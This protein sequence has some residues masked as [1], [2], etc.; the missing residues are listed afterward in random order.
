MRSLKPGDMPT[1]KLMSRFVACSW[2]FS[3]V[4]VVGWWAE[5]NFNFHGSAI[6]LFFVV[7]HIL[8]AVSIFQLVDEGKN[9]RQEV[10]VLK[11]KLGRLSTPVDFDALEVVR[12]KRSPLPARKNRKGR[13]CRNR[14]VKMELESA[15]FVPQQHSGD[16]VVSTER[17]EL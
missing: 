12:T 7:L 4:K 10:A 11:S 17:N 5:W 9:L 6:C 16:V 8:A 1:G 15:I 3:G 14:S 2:S 13:R